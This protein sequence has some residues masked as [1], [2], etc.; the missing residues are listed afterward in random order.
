MKALLLFFAVFLRYTGAAPLDTCDS[1]H[2]FIARGSIEPYPGR[3]GALV[4]AICEGI[5]SCGYDDIGYPATFS[6]YC[7]SVAVGVSNGTALIESYA[8]ACP[9]AK[10]VLTGYSQVTDII[11]H[12]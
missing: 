6:D 5:S 12:Q 2:I 9:E 7:S 8:A 4:T 11:S 10:L 3:Q 1:V